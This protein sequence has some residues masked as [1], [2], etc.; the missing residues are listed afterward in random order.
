MQF[1]S[2]LLPLL[3]TTDNSIVRD[4]SDE[5]ELDQFNNNP[6][7]DDKSLIKQT[8]DDAEH[9]NKILNM[10]CKDQFIYKNINKK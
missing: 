10:D 5:D 6:T 7:K 8:A 2:K 3:K 1:T 4:Q 9:E